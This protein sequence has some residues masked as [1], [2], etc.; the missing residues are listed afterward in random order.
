MRGNQNGRF[1]GTTTSKTTGFTNDDLRS[2]NDDLRPRNDDLRPMNDDLPPGVKRRFP[3]QITF[4]FPHG[5]LHVVVNGSLHVYH[6]GT[7]EWTDPKVTFQNA[8]GPSRVQE[9]AVVATEVLEHIPIEDI[10]ATWVEVPDEDPA[11]T[12]PLQEK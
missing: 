12:L 8:P 9:V 4:W 2:R 10:M 6:P 1:R 7:R 11:T 3:E 5:A